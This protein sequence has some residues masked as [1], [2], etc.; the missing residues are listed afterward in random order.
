MPRATIKRTWTQRK[1]GRET[2]FVVGDVSGVRWEAM[3][4]GSKSGWEITTPLG[5]ADAADVR[6]TL[7]KVGGGRLAVARVVRKRMGQRIRRMD[8][9]RRIDGL[10]EA[11]P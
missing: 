8:S 1:A 7:V 10:D 4:F 11:M 9:R 2:Y 3:T 6:A 5:P